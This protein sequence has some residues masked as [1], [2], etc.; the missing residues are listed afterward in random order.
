MFF[1]EERE[2]KMFITIVDK[3]VQEIDRKEVPM[4]EFCIGIMSN[5]ELQ[6]NYEEVG[7][8]AFAVEECIDNTSFFH[9]TMEVYDDFYL[10]IISIINMFEVERMKKDVGFILQ[11]NVLLFLTSE[12]E[13]IKQLKEIIF[14]ALERV[15]QNATPERMVTG[16]LDRLLFH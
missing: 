3:K 8:H 13:C 15:Q 11:K 10:G 7:I 6:E 9:N 12:E 4:Q 2:I 14:K 1:E 16:I 5:S